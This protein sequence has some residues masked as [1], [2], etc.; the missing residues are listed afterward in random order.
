MFS[1]LVLVCALAVVLCARY[2]GGHRVANGQ[3]PLAELT[4]DSLDSLKAE[5]NRSADG[6]R[7]IRENTG[8]FINSRS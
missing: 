5:F 1:A 4:N 2:F 7:I 8:N 3:P 6:V